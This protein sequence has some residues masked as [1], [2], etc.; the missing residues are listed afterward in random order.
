MRAV[1]SGFLQGLPGPALVSLVHVRIDI[2]PQ[3][4][5]DTPI[6][7]CGGRIQPGGLFKRADRLLMIKGVDKPQSLIKISL[8]FLGTG[9]DRVVQGPEILKESDSTR[10]ALGCLRP[11]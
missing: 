4:Q 11:L 10:H 6:G 5:C 7:H 9:S 2:W 3:G 1:G 8:C